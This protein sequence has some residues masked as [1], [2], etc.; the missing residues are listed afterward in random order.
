MKIESEN[1]SGIIKEWFKMTFIGFENKIRSKEMNS[2]QVN[3]LIKIVESDC[4]LSAAAKKAYVSQSALSQFITN[5]ERDNEIELFIRKN[6]RLSELSPS[7]KRIY[8]A[9]KK[10]ARIHKEMERIVL[11]ESD[12]QKG[13]I[14]I[15]LPSLILTVLFSNFFS[16]FTV[17]NP[18]I[19][20]QIFEEGS[21]EL[22]RMLS[23][24]ELDY[25]VLVEPAQLDSRIYEGNVIQIDEYK[26]FINPKHPLAKK[27][28][29]DWKDLSSY[30][31]ATFKESFVTNELV[32]EKLLK[33]EVDPSI[34]L[35][36]ASWDFLVETTYHSEIVTILPGP[37]HRYL[38]A[39][40]VI[41]KA[42]EDPIPFNVLL[43]R[44]IKES[45]HPVG[46]Y[47]HEEMLEHFLN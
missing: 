39:D 3:Y 16:R 5:F 8:T 19:E 18:S 35:T 44:P 30:Q 7:G 34:Q 31:L 2:N 32:L 25:A 29:I 33:A 15:G 23:E 11:E 41:M 17:E 20:L 13:T 38:E 9:A 28:K 10:I 4:N 47:F 37:I 43:T 36:S 46:N 6:G 26:A 27:S 12:K 22:K 42:M 21:H 1:E 14:R 40:A 45:Y 24:K